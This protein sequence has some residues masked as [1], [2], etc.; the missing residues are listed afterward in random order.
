MAESELIQTGIAGL[1]AIFLG[2]IPQ[3]NMILA[4]G[5]PGTG[6][7]LLGMEFIYRGI[8]A[9]QEPGII[10]HCSSDSAFAL[11]RPIERFYTAAPNLFSQGSPSCTDRADTCQTPA[12]ALPMSTTF[13]HRNS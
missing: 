12:R 8:T 3:G 4:E 9:Y 5:A 2:G 13:P 7:T 6:K 10:G 11:D 1:D